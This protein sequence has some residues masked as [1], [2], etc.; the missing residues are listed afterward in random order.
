MKIYSFEMEFALN[1][2]MDCI[3]ALE[4]LVINLES[5]TIS[6]IITSAQDL[7]RNST[8]RIGGFSL[9]DFKS[10][11]IIYAKGNLALAI[12][13]NC[14]LLMSSEIGAENSN[15][16]IELQINE[17]PTSV[18]LVFMAS[19]INEA[20]MLKVVNNLFKLLTSEMPSLKLQSKGAELILEFKTV[21]NKT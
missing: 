5:T 4:S 9:P 11:P 10:D 1:D 19:D 16:G 20:A 2:S 18:E 6:E 21:V 15:K 14:L 17:K 8:N 13:T 3:K 7:S 12:T